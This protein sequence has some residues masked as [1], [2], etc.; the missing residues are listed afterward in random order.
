MGIGSKPLKSRTMQNTPKFSMPE[1]WQKI[2]DG[3]QGII[4]AENDEMTAQ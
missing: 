2:L 1:K 4:G 3:D